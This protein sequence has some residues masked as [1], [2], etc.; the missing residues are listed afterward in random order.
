MTILKYK[1]YK[2]VPEFIT[3]KIDTMQVISKNYKFLGQCRINDDGILVWTETNKPVKFTDVSEIEFRAKPYFLPKMFTFL[4][5]GEK[6]YVLIRR[7]GATR[8]HFTFN[9]FERNTN[10]PWR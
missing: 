1:F 8:K 10:D 7:Y 9:V 4:N 5:K 6:Q 3:H 2:N